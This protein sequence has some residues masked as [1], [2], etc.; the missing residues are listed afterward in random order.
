MVKKSVLALL[1]VLALVAAPA[2]AQ[3]LT[4][5]ISGTVKDNSGV[6]L[7][8]TSVTI[9]APVLQ[10][11]RM[12]V[13]RSD[14]TYKVLNLPAGSGYQVAFAL[15]GFNTFEATNQEVRL[16]LDTQ[17]NATMQLS[18]KAE[19]VVTSEAPVVDVTQTNTQQ[20]FN[21]DY[22]KKI[23]IGT[24]NRSY[25][26]ILV[27]AA[28]VAGGSNPNVMGGNILENS[29]MI[30]GVNSTDSVTHTFTFNL[31][32]DA[33][34]EIALLT[35]GY[36][37]EYGRASGGVV[38]VVTKSGGNEFSGSFD[39]R[40]DNNKFVQNGDHYDNS[41]STSRNT[42][43]GV[44]L[45][46]PV[47][48]DALW[49]FGD[50]ARRD[51]YSSP[52]TTNQT[53]LSQNPTPAPQRFTG[54]NSGGKLS[55]TALPELNGFVSIQDSFANIPGATNSAAYRPEATNEQ[56]QTSRIFSL[57][58][59]GVFTQNWFGELNAGTHQS[60]V[61]SFPVTGSDAISGWQNRTGGG[62]W[63]D[64]YTNNQGGPRKRTLGGLSSTYFLSD[65]LGNHQI[66]AGYD[67]DKTEFPSWNY[68]TGTP[69]DPS[70]CPGFDGRTCGAYFT[71]NGF[72][73]AGNRIPYRQMVSERNPVQNRSARS[74]SGYIQDQWAPMSSLTFNLGV[75][76]DETKYDNNLGV[77]F[78]NFVKL[79]PRLSA[80]WDVVGDGKNRLS[81]DY[82]TYYID[83]ALTF[84][85][86]F[87]AGGT[88][89]VSR[90]YQWSTT[91]QKWNLLQQT[92]GNPVTASL[93]DGQLHPTW[94]EQIN[95]AFQRQITQGLSGTFTYVY[96]KTHDI[97]EDTCI[98][99]P[100]CADFWVSNQPGA[101][102]G[103]LDVL[104]KSY[105]GYM[106]QLDYRATRVQAN[107][108]YVYSKSQ[109]STD[110][111]STQYAGDDFDWSP[112]NYVNRYGYLADDARNRFKLYGTYRIPF[113]ETQFSAAYTYRSGLPY[114]VTSTSPG[115][116]GNIFVD[117]RGS[118]RATV[119]HNLDLELKK[120]FQVMGRLSVTPIVSVLNVFNDETP[121][122]YGGTVASASTLRQVTGWDRPRSFQVGF[123]IDWN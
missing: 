107:F 113:I 64:N 45:G 114:N 8:G 5:S 72:D 34:Q 69:S 33:I 99:Q 95:V 56:D 17:L 28:G 46:G 26:A 42:P 92:G 119:K 116:W 18:V 88:S 3:Q 105:Y 84:N 16:G 59:N 74:F 66:K 52:Y 1:V 4:G 87:N 75:R 20:N 93:I 96:K 22:L 104:K 65:A 36:A 102:L 77:N 94:D 7:P 44:T 120:Q 37:A 32:F 121:N 13:T 54:Y 47:V 9:T 57:K 112:D 27:Q 103:L 61:K 73:A 111:G 68:T 63:Y 25:Q 55:F 40:Y 109:G 19:I 83:P 80:A 62:V 117:P 39:V 24:A 58:L 21:S 82:G 50:T 51:S 53:I 6:G 123:R 10:G 101:K 89:P 86:L 85:R 81:A 78:M 29:Y 71:F 35:S 108:S 48:R 91:T 79:Q 11:T 23:P 106:F 14:G 97:F 115:G 2:M 122:A 41:L 110:A 67:M 60:E 38:N 100:E 15:S 98:T 76:W 118:N 12:A 49:F 70:F 43:W 90:T 30:D 31:N